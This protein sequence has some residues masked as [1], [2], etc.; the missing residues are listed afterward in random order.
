MKDDI[1]KHTKFFTFGMEY[2]DNRPQM[3]EGLKVA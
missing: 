1:M 3:L 2:H